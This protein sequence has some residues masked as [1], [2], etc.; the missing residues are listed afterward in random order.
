MGGIESVSHS[1]PSVALV[2][3]FYLTDFFVPE[4]KKRVT[5]SYSSRCGATLID[6]RTLLTAAHCL[7]DKVTF[8]VAG[9]NYTVKV[10]PNKYFK[11][12]ESMFT[13]FLGVQN[14]A[15]LYVSADIA[16]AINVQVSKVIKHEEYDDI[17]VKNDIGLILLREDAELN[18]FVQVA[19]LPST[20]SSEYP[21]VDETVYAV[22]W[23]QTEFLGDSSDELQNVKLTVYDGT[24][25]CHMYDIN[26]WKR[27]ICAGD[28]KGGKDT[29]LGL[30]SIHI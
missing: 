25:K 4:L 2:D 8:E 1:W 9:K 19:C 17:Q 22:G 7:V 10:E 30:M 20:D 24:S 29:C 12:L 14:S 5:K 27:Q 16:P 11:T 15:N 3:F 18:E 6:K 23:G 13:V 28:L 21:S 26:E